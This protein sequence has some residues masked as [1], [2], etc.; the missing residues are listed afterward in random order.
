[1]RKTWECNCRINNVLHIQRT[2]AI[3]QC[4]QCTLQ[5]KVWKNTLLFWVSSADCTSDDLYF[6]G[7]RS[8][9]IQETSCRANVR[10]F[11]SRAA[12]GGEL[13]LFGIFYGLNIQGCAEEQ[14]LHKNESFLAL[15]QFEAMCST[16]GIARCGLYLLIR[17]YP[18][19]KL[20]SS[21]FPRLMCYF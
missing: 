16:H 1:M 17:K 15:L 12:L 14:K 2:K 21:C 7:W 11:L 8:T 3:T 5:I 20:P 4:I 10:D 13:A 9:L 18:G 6:A 19:E